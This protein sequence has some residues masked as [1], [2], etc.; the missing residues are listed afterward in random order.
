MG[1]HQ[2]SKYDHEQRTPVA[3]QPASLSFGQDDLRLGL[4]LRAFGLDEL[5][6]DLELQLVG[7]VLAPEINVRPT[8][9]ANWLAFRNTLH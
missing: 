6:L 9:S 3:L 7:L 1:D 2:T 8:T 5:P 4:Q